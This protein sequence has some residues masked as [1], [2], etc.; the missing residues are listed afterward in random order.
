MWLRGPRSSAHVHPAPG[1]EA[2]E[3][4]EEAGGGAGLGGGGVRRAVRDAV[5]L[6]ARQR[7]AG[8][9]VPGAVGGQRRAPEGGEGPE[10]AAAAWLPHAR[11]SVL[12]HRSEA[13]EGSSAEEG[14]RHTR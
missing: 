4:G 11:L 13:A 12:L 5:G 9:A 14:A 7:P 2:E 3:A 10:L 6:R 1:A 8:G